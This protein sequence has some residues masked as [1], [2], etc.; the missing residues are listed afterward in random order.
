VR[1]LTFEEAMTWKFYGP[2]GVEI[3]RDRQWW[4]P[5]DRTAQIYWPRPSGE[6]AA[7]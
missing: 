7:K 2:S 3:E 4:E 5:M 6:T 1:K